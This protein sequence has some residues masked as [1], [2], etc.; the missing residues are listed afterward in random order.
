MHKR[1]IPYENKL[2]L[3]CARLR[4]NGIA[5]QEIKKLLDFPIDWNKAI[6]ISRHQQILPF[7]YHNLNGLNLQNFVPKD[8]FAA[9]KNDYYSN[10]LRNSLIEKEIF[11][12]LEAT[13]K[14]NI[15]I[16]PFRGFGL[17][18]AVYHNSALRTMV[19]IDIL[20]KEEDFPRIKTIFIQLG[21]QENADIVF[22]KKLSSSQSLVIEIHYGLAPAR[23][24][25]VNL[26]YLWERT[27]EKI[28]NGQRLACLSP[29]DTFLSLVL[30]LRRHTRRLTLKFI[31]DI[32]ELLNTSHDKLDWAYIK[33]SAQNNHF[34]TSV[35]IS[36]YL[37]KEL[38]A[39]NISL[40]I[41][42]A[43]RPNIIKSTLVYFTINKYN[44]F[45]LTERQGIFL[46]LLLFDRL[47][48][49]FFYLWRVSFLERLTSKINII[50]KERIKK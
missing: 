39:T 1:M 21:Y 5:Q 20:A 23:P 30:H 2:I 29:E 10:L 26:P 43:F 7:L 47:I 14:E 9:M 17:I 4:V 34:I 6:E 22:S 33:K 32:A 25:K 3:L 37:A 27:Q 12:I 48:D 50:D 19:D 8:I 44:F 41:L 35:Y 40:K 38:L 36:L 28:T 49:F 16:I 24:Y 18:Q 11:S 46:R 15:I 42:N 13:N 31:V 45:E